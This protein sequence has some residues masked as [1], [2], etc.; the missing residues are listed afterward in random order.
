M[1]SSAVAWTSSPVHCD[2]GA[3]EGM[4]V[5]ACEHTL[6]DLERLWQAGGATALGECFLVF[7]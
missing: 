7:R 1:C 3:H 5:T 4:F 2:G 6:E